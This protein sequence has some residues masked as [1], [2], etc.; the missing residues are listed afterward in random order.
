MET[1]L[2]G[3][4]RKS[5]SGP[6][7]AGIISGTIGLILSFS[8]RGLTVARPLGDPMP[9]MLSISQIP[10]GLT[11]FPWRPILV[12]FLFAVMLGVLSFFVLVLINRDSANTDG[13]AKVGRIAA[14]INVGVV[15]IIAVDAVVVGFWYLISGLVSVV[16]TGYAARLAAILW[17][18]R[19]GRPIR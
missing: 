5:F 2:S 11:Y 12:H 19:D 7:P 18:R 13:A 14:V 10:R 8:L 3:R 16:L 9:L 15:A 4:L 6:W 17:R 1:N